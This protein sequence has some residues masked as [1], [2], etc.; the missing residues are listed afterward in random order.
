MRTLYFTL[1]LIFLFILWRSF[2]INN[3]TSNVVGEV[4]NPSGEGLSNVE[5]SL[6]TNNHVPSG[7]Y[8]PSN[9]CGSFK[10]TF[11]SP[12]GK[13]VLF[14]Y[15]KNYYSTFIT[16]FVP[17]K[18]EVTRVSAICLIRLIP[19]NKIK[20]LPKRYSFNLFENPNK[21]KPQKYFL[22]EIDYFSS[23]QK[24]NG[25][26]SISN[27]TWYEV[28]FNINNDRQLYRGFFLEQ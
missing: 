17:R 19:K 22:D 24:L 15:Q 25:T 1:F 6:L 21:K 23:I 8:E 16:E 12:E 27:E 18:S 20:N 5:V 26:D 14:R 4:I 13:P 7:Y 28:T 2:T 11:N 10:L 3:I 9:Q